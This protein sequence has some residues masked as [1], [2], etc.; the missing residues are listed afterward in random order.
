MS[1]NKE[2]RVPSNDSD[3][4]DRRYL[5]IEATD[6][7]E[8]SKT[9][10][11]YYYKYQGERPDRCYNCKL[12]FTSTA[13]AVKHF[14][15][16]CYFLWCKRCETTFKTKEEREEH[17]VHGS[18]HWKCGVCKFD[19]PTFKLQEGHWKETGHRYE[20]RGCNCWYEKRYWDKHLAVSFACCRCHKHHG[21]EEEQKKHEADHLKEA[22]VFECIGRCGK[23]LPSLGAMYVHLESGTCESS[24]DAAD[25]LRC[26]ALHQGAEYLLIKDRK[27][28]LKLILD[29][30]EP[31]TNCLR[32]PGQGCGNETF[33]VFSSFLLHTMGKRCKFEFKSGPE[34]MLVHLENNLFLDVAIGRIKALVEATN[35]GIQ[36]LSL[37]PEYSKDR[38]PYTHMPDIDTLRPFFAGVCRAYQTCVKE[39]IFK[40]SYHVKTQGTLKIRILKSFVREITHFEKMYGRAYQ[41]YTDNVSHA[42]RP[43][44][45]ILIYF[46]ATKASQ[47]A[48]KFLKDVH[49]VSKIFKLMAEFESPK[50]IKYY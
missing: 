41:A 29:G 19:A 37:L 10:K 8:Y 35:S 21:S 5:A 48:W 47:P 32:C 28:I 16:K 7:I 22:G 3:K 27:G 6:T 39:L 17:F 36:V 13:E 11:E 33:K 2:N 9:Q 24:I 23:E 42:P 14:E 26:F 46:Q 25:V 50:Y 18:A 44:G 30:K 31:R 43:R 34:S 1:S 40:Q 4:G 15:K 49:T 12:A 45:D 20:C 38:T